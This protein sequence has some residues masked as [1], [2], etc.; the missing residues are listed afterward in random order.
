VAPAHGPSAA[1]GDAGAAEA[2]PAAHRD[3]VLRAPQDPLVRLALGGL[4][5]RLG[6]T[7]E[8]IAVLHAAATLAPGLA[9]AQRALGAALRDLGRLDEAETALRAAV[10]LDTGDASANDLGSWRSRGATPRRSRRSARRWRATRAPP[11]PAPICAPR[12]AR[13]AAST[14]RRR[15][16]RRRCGCGRTMPTHKPI[17]V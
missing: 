17:S 16:G 9:T 8:A 1:A 14:R 5:R 7:K 15:W 4:L 12:S 10:T 3:A 6:R 11:T 13:W 2:E